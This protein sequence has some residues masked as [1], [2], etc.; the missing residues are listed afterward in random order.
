MPEN[1]TSQYSKDLASQQAEE[2]RKAQAA[3]AAKKKYPGA[4]AP[5]RNPTN[6]EP[7]TGYQPHGGPGGPTNVSQYQ[8]GRR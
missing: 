3:A 7:T 6:P 5:F 1:S 8:Q 2:M 4:S